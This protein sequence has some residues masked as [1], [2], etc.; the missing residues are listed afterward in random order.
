MV[1]LRKDCAGEW[2]MGKRSM[3][4]S[5]PRYL[6]RATSELEIQ[7]GNINLKVYVFIENNTRN[8]NIDLLHST[9][10]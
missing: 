7:N 9:F 3:L 8:W 5:M 6:D 2:E 1:S 10:S 4:P